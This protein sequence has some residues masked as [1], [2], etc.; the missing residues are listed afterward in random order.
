MTT[1]ANSMNLTLGSKRGADL[2]NRIQIEPT[3]KRKRKDCTLRYVQDLLTK[4]EDAKIF[5]IFPLLMLI[6]D[7]VRNA[8]MKVRVRHDILRARGHRAK[9]RAPPWEAYHYPLY[10]PVRDIIERFHEIDYGLTFG[11]RIIFSENVNIRILHNEKY[12][13]TSSMLGD[14]LYELGIKWETIQ[15]ENASLNLSRK[16][17]LWLVATIPKESCIVQPNHTIDNGYRQ[18]IHELVYKLPMID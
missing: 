2:L 16:S 12:L 9:R 3:V 14:L 8:D 7:Y 6:A 17:S 1:T 13:D 5:V 11:G 15:S 10:V 4:L 18:V